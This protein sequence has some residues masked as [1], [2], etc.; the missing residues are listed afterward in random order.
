MV[1]C[2]TSQS[3]PLA[4]DFIPASA[5]RQL[6]LP[7]APVA[8]PRCSADRWWPAARPVLRPTVTSSTVR[9]CTC[10]ASIRSH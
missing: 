10:G 9:P 6:A 2:A 5:R 3:G 4:V 7:A 1:L 8:C